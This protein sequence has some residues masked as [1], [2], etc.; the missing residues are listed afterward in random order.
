MCEKFELEVQMMMSLGKSWRI[1]PWS[2]I[3]ALC[4][5]T[6]R[7]VIEHPR[8]YYIFGLCFLSIICICVAVGG[9]S[10]TPNFHL[11]LLHPEQFIY[12]S[13]S[14]PPRHIQAHLAIRR[15]GQRSHSS[16]F[17]FPYFFHSNSFLSRTPVSCAESHYNYFFA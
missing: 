6:F 5:F 3:G 1:L 9:G 7:L 17:H 4:G 15:K 13:P 2:R 12:S 8:G 10:G 11:P 16:S 14:L